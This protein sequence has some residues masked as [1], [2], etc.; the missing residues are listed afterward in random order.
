MNTSKLTLTVLATAALTANR[1]CT[2][3]GALPTLKG[4]AVGVCRA[5]AATGELCP[6]DVLGTAMVECSAGI[7]AGAA[8]NVTATGLAV[9]HTDG[10]IVGRALTGGATGEL[11]E[12]LLITN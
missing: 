12:V 9:T 8:I 6:V 4:N 3:V 11:I 5:G 10:V 1:F 2:A 7:A